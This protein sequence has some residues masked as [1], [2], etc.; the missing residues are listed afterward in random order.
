MGKAILKEIVLVVLVLAIIVLLLGIFFYDDIPSMKVI[1]SVIAYQTPDNVKNELA[2]S[3][4]ATGT[5][6][7]VASYSIDGKDLSVYEQ[8]KDYAKGKVNP[9]ASTDTS[10]QVVEN[11]D[12][13][14]NTSTNEKTE[15]NTTTNTSTE[16][17]NSSEGTFYKSTGMK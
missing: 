10:S 15:K 2:D 4:V 14:E 13:N 17:E 5:E 11:K 12:N 3:I 7:T 8:S 16:K 1:P 9:F 6:N